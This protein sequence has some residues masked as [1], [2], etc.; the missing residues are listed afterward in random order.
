VVYKSLV[1]GTGVRGARQLPLLAQHKR[2]FPPDT[3][4]TREL[5]KPDGCFLVMQGQRSRFLYYHF[6]KMSQQMAP[7]QAA[8]FAYG[9]VNP[10][11]SNPLRKAGLPH[12][13]K[14]S[15]LLTS[16]HIRLT[17]CPCRP[18]PSLMIFLYAM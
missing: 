6:Q 17:R 16:L 18:K 1:T 3:S 10:G 8:P 2:E 12:V 9:S 13:R 4:N 14:T 7:P 5:S 15:L 11:S